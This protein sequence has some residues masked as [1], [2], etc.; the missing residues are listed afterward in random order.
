MSV[1][2]YGEERWVLKS[3]E[4]TYWS[5]GGGGWYWNPEQTE[6]EDTFSTE[7]ACKEFQKAHSNFLVR[8]KAQ[9]HRLLCRFEEKP[10]SFWKDKENYISSEDK[11]PWEIPIQIS[12][13]CGN[14]TTHRIDMRELIDS[15]KK[16]G[17]INDREKTKIIS[18]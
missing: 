18:I 4:G 15:S 12:C 14:Q 16:G 3:E 17:C 13:S 5:E 2:Y 8:E 6:F 10:E 9:P 1:P 7:E 11:D